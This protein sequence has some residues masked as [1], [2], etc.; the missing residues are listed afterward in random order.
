MPTPAM[1]S[2]IHAPNRMPPSS[3]TTGLAVTSSVF[4]SRCTVSSAAVSPFS[5]SMA[6]KC[7]VERIFSPL[8]VSRI[9][10]SFRPHSLA[11]ERVSS[12]PCTGDTDTTSTPSAK[13]LMPT[14]LPTGINCR[15][16]S[17]HVRCHPNDRASTIASSTAAPRR[18][19]RLACVSC[20]GSPLIF[21]FRRR[22]HHYFA[23]QPPV[24][25]A[26][27]SARHGNRPARLSRRR[28]CAAGKIFRSEAPAFRTPPPFFSVAAPPTPML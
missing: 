4:P 2:R 26:L 20:I 16:S 18:T 23:P 7:S 21:C 14:A 27:N 11:G 17:A 19:P 9:S 13:S 10:P 8:K 15:P 1:L 6:C 25:S 3:Q 12:V 22:R 28:F 24:S 5:A